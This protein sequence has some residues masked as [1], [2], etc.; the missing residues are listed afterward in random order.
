MKLPYS[1]QFN[2]LGC[3]YLDHGFVHHVF[4]KGDRVFKI[5]K[6]EFPEANNM[7]KY[8]IESRSLEILRANGLPAAEVIR[9]HSEG[10]L[11]EDY[12]VLEEMLV[13]GYVYER[14]LIGQRELASI[15]EFLVNAAQIALPIGPLSSHPEL[16]STTVTWREYFEGRVGDAAAIAQA[17]GMYEAFQ[18][19][20]N[21]FDFSALD[22]VPCGFLVMEPNQANYFFDPA[23]SLC[24]V[25]DIDHP[26][27]GDMNYQWAAIRYHRP[28]FFDVYAKLDRN[29]SRNL[30]TISFYQ[31]IHALTD[32]PIRWIYFRSRRRVVQHIGRLI[33]GYTLN[34]G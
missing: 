12:C 31:V 2:E 33:A 13:R 29:I 25:I 24:A 10:E 3:E 19:A 17:L 18:Q 27:V 1:R 9:V 32:Y 11:I 34:R 14:H 6:P 4:R 22:D 30:E 26:L 7:E 8:L 5:A 28:E 16:Q 20:T 23:G 15:F 21:K